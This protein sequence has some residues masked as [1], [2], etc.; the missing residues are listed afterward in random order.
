MKLA[1]QWTLSL[2]MMIA[3]SC[4]LEQTIPHK[5]A[6]HLKSKNRKLMLGAFDNADYVNGGSSGLSDAGTKNSLY[7]LQMLVN[8]QKSL[9]NYKIV[10]NWLTDMESKLDDMRDA[11]NRRLADMGNSIQRRNT[12]SGHYASMGNSYVGEEGGM[13]PIMRF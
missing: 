11:V 10:G 12:M 2:L 3:I 7:H 4:C 9:H 5:E 6:R 13:S 8:Q 1:I